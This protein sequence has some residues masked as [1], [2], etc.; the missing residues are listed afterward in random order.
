VSGRIIH[1]QPEM[2]FPVNLAT[3]KKCFALFHLTEV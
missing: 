3:A 1:D 2:I